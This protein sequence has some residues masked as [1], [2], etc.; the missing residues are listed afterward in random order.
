MKHLLPLLL[1]VFCLFQF[2]CFG[3]S[4]GKPA[5]T[6]F[7]YHTVEAARDLQRVAILPLYRHNSVGKAANSLDSALASAFREL[8]QYEIVTIT[9]KDRDFAFGKEL[10]SLRVITP[11]HL[12]KFRE[13]HHVDAI[14]IGRIDAFVSFDPIVVGLES[15]LISCQNGDTYWSA[16]GHFDGKHKAIQKDIKDW[17]KET[18]GS[19]QQSIGG[20]QLTLQSPS[21]FSR[22][23]TDRLV[24]SVLW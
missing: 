9:E 5:P 3:R 1:A 22:F 8:G 6:S 2:G 7:S 23:V 14:V 12:R 18:I 13:S 16:S 21:L 4:G 20:W 10:P 11:E 15:H 24:E 17:Y 19:G